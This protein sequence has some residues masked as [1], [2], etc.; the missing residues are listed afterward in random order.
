MDDVNL[1]AIGHSDGED[2]KHSIE[3]SKELI[4]ILQ[5]KIIVNF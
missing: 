3:Y 2:S 1:C 5:K 4:E